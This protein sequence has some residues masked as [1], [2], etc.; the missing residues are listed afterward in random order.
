M[1]YL[2]DVPFLIAM[3]ALG[4]LLASL[5]LASLWYTVQ[6]IHRD[7]HPALWLVTS[8]TV[9]MVL[10]LAAFYFILGEGHWERLLTALAGFVTLRTL[11]IRHV[12]QTIPAG[13]A[14]E[15][16]L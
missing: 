7:S 5:Y 13:L 6:R 4:A 11:A 9:R 16:L 10:L 14:K 12:R 1:N 15:K 3:F 2:H 8:L